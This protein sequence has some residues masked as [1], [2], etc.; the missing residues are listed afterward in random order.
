MGLKPM[1]PE[2]ELQQPENLA[3][4]APRAKLATTWGQAKEH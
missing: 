1:I 2:S 4:V 3:A